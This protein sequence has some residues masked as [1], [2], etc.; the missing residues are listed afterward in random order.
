MEKSKTETERLNEMRL[1]AVEIIIDQMERI[2]ND[3]MIAK[4]SRAETLCK[5]ASAL[6]GIQISPEPMD[7]RDTLNKI[8]MAGCSAPAVDG[9]GK[10]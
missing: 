2:K 9:G 8:A 3:D 5:L 7:F 10:Q 4:E 1:E 6:F